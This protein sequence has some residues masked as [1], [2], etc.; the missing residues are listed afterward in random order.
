MLRNGLF[1][2]KYWAVTRAPLVGKVCQCCGKLESRRSR[3]EGWPS[4]QI[5]E[6]SVCL[7]VHPFVSTREVEM[8]TH[9]SSMLLRREMMARGKEAREEKKKSTFDHETSAFL[10]MCDHRHFAEKKKSA[11]PDR[12][13]RAWTEKA[14]FVGN[15]KTS[16]KTL[17]KVA[18]REYASW[19]KKSPNK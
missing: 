11:F 1:S 10:L 17:K 3:K 12:K 19:I 16:K 9:T 7:S 4:G 5:F 14:Y 13:H 15:W 6:L 18:L 2:V 8:H